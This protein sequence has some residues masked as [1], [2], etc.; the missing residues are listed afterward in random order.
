MLPKRRG[1]APFRFE[2]EDDNG[3]SIDMALSKPRVFVVIPNWNA[4]D[5]VG[6]CLQALERQTL[7]H[8]VIIVEN[9]S[10]DGSAEFIRETFPHLQLLA[11]PDNAGFAGGVNRGIRPAL[12]QGAD[13]VVLLNND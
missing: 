5:F 11:F 4:R 12:E 13:Y 10:T 8:E 1:R 3:S 9:G 7:P 6:E 2:P